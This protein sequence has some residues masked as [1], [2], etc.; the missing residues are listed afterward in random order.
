MA[1]T[2]AERRALR[3]RISRYLISGLLQVTP[4]DDYSINFMMKI[5]TAHAHRQRP[6]PPRIMLS[7]DADQDWFQTAND[8]FW[9]V[10]QFKHQ[11]QARQLSARAT[12]L[13]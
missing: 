5:A 3:A 4:R 11:Q 10:R 7:V 12:L 1:G 6:P 9:A 8:I 13:L 2:P